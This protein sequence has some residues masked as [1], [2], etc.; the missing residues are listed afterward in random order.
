ME[1]FRELPHNKLL[2]ILGTKLPTPWLLL[3]FSMVMQFYGKKEHTSEVYS[4]QSDQGFSRH[5]SLKNSLNLE[6]KAK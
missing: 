3:I 5:V 4:Q 2:V 1:A 6:T